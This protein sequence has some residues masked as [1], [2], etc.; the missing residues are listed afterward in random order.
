MAKFK[1]LAGEHIGAALDLPEGSHLL[2]SSPDCLLQVGSSDKPTAILITVTAQGVSAAL[3][4][5]QAGRSV[6]SRS[7]GLRDRF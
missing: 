6:L 5:G 7:R 3:Q 4:E 2:G 1:F